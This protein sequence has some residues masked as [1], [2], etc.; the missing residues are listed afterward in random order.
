MNKPIIH[1]AHGNGFPS[2]CYQSLFTHLQDSFSVTY[3]DR[4]G[5]DKNFPVTEN[6]DCLV[7]EVIASIERQSSEAVVAVGHSLGGI[8][9]LRA[10]FYRPEL[11]KAVILLDAPMFG[12]VK[13]R[14]LHFSKHVGLIEHI[15]PA[16]R[17]KLRRQT[18]PTKQKAFDYFR[19]KE[20]FKHFAEQCLWDYV[21]YGLEVTDDGFALRFDRTVEYQIYRTIPHILPRYHNKLNVPAAMI[22]GADSTVVTAND[23]RNMRR[24]FDMEIM[25]MQGSHMF[26]LEFPQQTTENI[27]KIFNKL[28]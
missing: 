20:V 22:Y 17:T 13:S 28:R 19:T 16:H 8:L 6:W 23:R 10:A 21:N 18:W 15:T 3:I 24:N 1:F 7:E 14:L 26:P 11:F 27:I 5:H 12:R 9:S 2:S 4:I 25:E